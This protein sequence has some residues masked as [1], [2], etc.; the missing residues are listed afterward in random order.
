MRVFRYLFIAILGIAITSAFAA[1]PVFYYSRLR[2]SGGVGLYWKTMPV[3]YV[4]NDQ[5]SKNIPDGSDD[6]AFRL[7]FKSWEDLT[8]ASISFT[9][10][11]TPSEKAKTDYTPS[12]IHLMYF[13][14]TG[15]TGLI[16]SGSGII[17]LTPVSF[18]TSP[19]ASAGQIADADIVFNG[20]DFVFSTSA[21]PGTVDLQSVATHEAGHFIGLDHEAIGGATMYPYTANQQINQRSVSSDDAAGAEA[22]YPNVT[23]GTITGT[24]KRSSDSSVVKGAHVWARS[25]ADGRDATAGY[26]DDSGNF[27]ITGLPAGNYRV[28]VEPLNQPVDAS[29]FGG[30]TVGTVQTD[31]RAGQSGVLAVTS[32]ATTPAGDVL[33]GANPAF[34]ITNPVKETAIHPSETKIIHFVGTLPAVGNTTVSMPDTATTFT[35]GYA[36]GNNLTITP[37]AGAAAGLYDVMLHD[38]ASGED[39]LYCGSIE[40]MPPVQT[41]NNVAPVSG[42]TAGGTAVTIT[43]TNFSGTPLVVFGDALGTSVN[44]NSA[45]QITVTSPAHAS[46]AVDIVIINSG[47]EEARSAGAF[48]FSSGTQP[49]LVSIFPTSGSTSGGE[50]VTLSGSSFENG[51]AVKFGNTQSASVTF[52]D[53]TQLTA[54]APALGAGAH[55]VI[56]TNPGALG[57]ASTLANAF[58][59]VAQPA[60]IVTSA[61]PAITSFLGGESIT[62]QGSNFQNGLTLTLF[63]KIADGTGGTLAPTTSV[64]P[65]QIVFTAPAGTVS[66]ATIFVQNP[67]GLSFIG[68]GILDYAYFANGSSTLKGKINPLNDTDTILQDAIAGSKV[69]IT[70]TQDKSSIQPK[71]VLK[72]AAD[73]VLISSDLNDAQF[74]ATF[75]SATT[76]SAAIKN[77]IL[78]STQRYKIVVSGLAGSTGKYKCT[79][80][81][82]IPAAAKSIKYKNVAV[83]PGDGTVNF[84]AKAGSVLKGT[85]SSKGGLLEIVSALGGPGGSILADPAVSSKIVI[86]TKGNSIKF[87]SVPLAAFGSYSLSIGQSGGTTGLVNGT[88]TIVPPKATVAATEQ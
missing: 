22:I 57:L 12:S 27:T 64:T 23:R 2:T 46:G 36:A 87:N 10:I 6:L 24:I 79:V 70:V 73:V 28:G 25:T 31:F 38:T 66:D 47:G 51:A 82:T 67:S 17:A 40:V 34:N 29:N 33:V 61:T 9:E 63:A 49:S 43:G 1:S 85:L 4:I 77:F 55:D 42:T 80:K 18:F 14:E 16:P 11:T 15:A 48:T 78:N 44:V 37:G 53:S 83:G 81:E 20:Q 32:G 68:S 13:D 19:P 72:D 65:T 35:L 41:I 75:A 21:A 88:L 52:V 69:T 5:G 39:I 74:N 30:T 71:V 45:T 76:K 84:D 7:A 60:P 62:L 54:L 59:A 56:V 8:G 26:S 3:T 58:T 86:S 50:V